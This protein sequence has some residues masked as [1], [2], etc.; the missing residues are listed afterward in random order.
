VIESESWRF[1]IQLQLGNQW[2][3]REVSWF[4]K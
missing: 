2:F 1:S 3:L 4:E